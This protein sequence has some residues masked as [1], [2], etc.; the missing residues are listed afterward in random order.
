MEQKKRK[1]VKKLDFLPNRLNHYSIRKFTIGTAS[2]LVGSAL[3]FGIG[4][5]AK[6]D[7]QASHST[8]QDEGVNKDKANIDDSVQESASTEE[9]STEEKAPE[10][11]STEEVS[12]EEKAP[13][14]ES[15]E[16]ASTEEK[17]PEAET[18]EEAS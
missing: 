13:E 18:T 9:A 17:A 5:E 11:E 3:L 14:T 7:E 8:V 2:I 10:T 6:A 16:E 15:T 12:T 4:S 1:R